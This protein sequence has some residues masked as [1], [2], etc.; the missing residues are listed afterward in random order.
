MRSATLTLI[1]ATTILASCRKGPGIR[2][3]YPL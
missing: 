3:P 1:L 2:T